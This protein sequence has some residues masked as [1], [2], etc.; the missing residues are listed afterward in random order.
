MEAFSQRIKLL[1][2]RLASQESKHG[3]TFV[4]RVKRDLTS[5][6]VLL[7]SCRFPQVPDDYYDHPLEDR[8]K[9]LGVKPNQLCKSLL[10]QNMAPQFDE[11]EGPGSAKFYLIIVQY[12]SKFSPDK[13]RAAIQKMRPPETRQQ[14]IDYRMA[15]QEI[16][17]EV[18]GF[19]HN[20]VSPFGLATKIPI[21]LSE[22][23]TRECK[24]LFMGGGAVNVKLGMAMSSFLACASPIV[25][26]ISDPR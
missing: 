9:L 1:E 5:H 25:A 20:A 8:A 6:G 13:L 15:A 7:S 14:K 19:Q 21:L 12:A 10:F 2:E 26:D 4:A 24:Y 18:T 11:S 16:N 17:D 23:C 22:A 3:G